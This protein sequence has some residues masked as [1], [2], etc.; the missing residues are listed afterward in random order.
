MKPIYIVG[1]GPGEPELLTVKAQ[2][3]LREADRIVWA[4][5]LI[6][7]AIL[8]MAKPEVEI[9]DSSKLTLEEIISIL[10]EGYRKDQLVI[11]LHTGDPSIYGAIGEQIRLLDDHNIPWEVVPGVS[12]FLATAATLGIEYTVPELTQT[13]ILTRVEGRTPMPERESLAELAKH[14][15]TLCIFLSIQQLNKTVREL[16][17]VLPGT[18][19][20]A[21]VEKASWPDE[22]IVN[23]T[24]DD[25]EAKV[26]TSGIERTAMIVVGKCLE[27]NIQRSKLYNPRFEHGYRRG[28]TDE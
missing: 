12:S 28:R 27:G 26:E 16:K 3:L 1:A 9:F 17:S 13:V 2:R 24:L 23:G 5:S 7:P 10:E 15:S 11:R 21:V 4:G 25:I 20:V 8:E 6:N 22:Q 18:T 14:Q 19:R